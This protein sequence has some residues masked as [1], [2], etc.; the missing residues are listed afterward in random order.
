MTSDQNLIHGS[1]LVISFLITESDELML[2]RLPDM[3]KNVIN[4]S[5]KKGDLI[6][7]Q[8]IRMFPNMAEANPELFSKYADM[9]I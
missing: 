8:C 3:F 7:P 2:D 1:L 4:Q 6:R 9:V 5:E